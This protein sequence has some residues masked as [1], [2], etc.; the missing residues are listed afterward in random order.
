MTLLATMLTPIG[1]LMH[2]RRPDEKDSVR[3][4]PELDSP[5]T[6]GLSSPAFTQGGTIPDRH[7]SMDLGPN[8]SPELR[9]SGVP[10]RTAQLL[11]IIE[12]IDAP[13]RLPSLHTIALLAPERI[14]LAEGE[15]TP[16]NEKIRYVPGVRGR[17]GYLGPRP[18][19][20]HGLHRYG[21]H[22]YALDRAIT[23][24]H[25]LTGLPDLLAA[26]DGHAIANGFLEG[27]KKG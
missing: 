16:D 2:N 17:T 25:K 27:T 4:A 7:A 1:R 24:E 26:V 13:A 21:F 18:M 10:G 15:L 11:F 3:H 20:G 6:L 23:P 5:R 14:G 9:W 19:P 12:D 8:I 22:L